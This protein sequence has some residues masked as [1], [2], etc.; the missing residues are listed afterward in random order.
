[1][2]FKSKEIG[3]FEF[4]FS[5]LDAYMKNDPAA[6]NRIEVLLLYPGVRAI[7]LYKISNALWKKNF[8]FS[9]RFISEC[10]KII[11]GI[12]IHPAAKLG[13]NIVIDHGMGIV[14]GETAEIGDN[15]LIYHGVT[16]GSV[17]LDSIKRHPTIGANV[18]LGAGSKILGNIII[19]DGCKIGANCVVTKDTPPHTTWVGN[20]A[21]QIPKK[22][23]LN[24]SQPS[25][26]KISA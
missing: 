19:G 22:S 13:R 1:M 20:P 23:K 21:V 5:L 12:E 9:A 16:L 4:V 8:K 6:R 3:Y 25:L 7:L 17:S 10:A 14:I 11:T 24:P 26:R 2:K 15:T 18:M